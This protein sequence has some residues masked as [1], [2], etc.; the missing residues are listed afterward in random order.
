MSLSTWKAADGFCGKDFA[1][2]VGRTLLGRGLTVYG[3]L[4]CCGIAHDSQRLG[5]SGEVKAARRAFL[6]P[7]SEGAFFAITKAVEFNP[8]VTAET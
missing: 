8:H 3:S 5:C 1:Q 2:D 6:L 4:G 7:H